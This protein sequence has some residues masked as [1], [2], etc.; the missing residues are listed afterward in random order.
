MYTNDVIKEKNYL[1]LNHT[2]LYIKAIL[3]L[4]LNFV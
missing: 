2:F 4:F 3:N 1:K